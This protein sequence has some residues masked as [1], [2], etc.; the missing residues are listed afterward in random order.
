[1]TLF[2]CGGRPRC[3]THPALLGSQAPFHLYKFHI[4]GIEWLQ[5]L[6]SFSE[7]KLET[8][9]SSPRTGLRSWFCLRVWE[10]RFR[11]SETNLRIGLSRP[12]QG[13][14]LGSGMEHA[15]CREPTGLEKENSLG[16]GRLDLLLGTQWHPLWCG[17]RHR[18]GTEFPLCWRTTGLCQPWSWMNTGSYLR[19]ACSPWCHKESDTTEQLNN[20]NNFRIQC[21]LLKI[22]LIYLMIYSKGTSNLLRECWV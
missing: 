21:V 20:S 16:W 17:V 15:G 12:G 8:Q 7:T 22:W 9:V 10:R 5:K 3:S 13:A 1:M 19:E 6:P 4:P 14:E 11:V 2:S 18:T